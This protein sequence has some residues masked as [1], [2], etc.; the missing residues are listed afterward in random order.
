M[1]QKTNVSRAMGATPYSGNRL[2]ALDG[3]RAVA[4]SLV[5]L[6]H[7]G[8][9]AVATTIPDRQ[10]WQASL[11]R[12]TVGSTAS[13]VELFF[14]LSAIVLAG[15][16]VRGERHFSLGKYAVRRTARLLPP[17][18]AAWLLAGAQIY[19]MT[20]RPTWWSSQSSLPSFSWTDWLAQAG[21]IYI[22]HHPYNWAWWS[23]TIEVAFYATLPW[24]IPLVIRT[25]RWGR[26]LPIAFVTAVIVATALNW[27]G[28]ADSVP[29]LSQL[30]I[31]GS[32]FCA[33]LVI[34][35]KGPL[36]RPMRN[37]AVGI[38]ATWVLVSAIFPQLNAHVGWGLLYFGA[39]SMAMDRRTWLARTLS[40][41]RFVWLGERS[42]SLYLVHY[43][44][45]GL[46]C[47][48]A[49]FIIAA[50]NLKYFVLTRA[51]SL[52]ASFGAAV[53]LFGLIERRFAH[54]LVTANMTWP[55]QRQA[56]GVSPPSRNSTACRATGRPARR[57]PGGRAPCR[58]S[59]A[60]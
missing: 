34:A 11:S 60:P 53:F 5:L 23:L 35:A 12:L 37:A 8:A 52:I 6:H 2:H 57:H 56:G 39:V 26:G 17:Y 46:V 7:L 31:Y 15:P 41:F 58:S 19:L 44:M 20:V 10:W 18:F 28:L 45:I 21:I 47:Y 42:Y 59:R 14:V 50:K 25:N 22:G 33:G 1:D 40:D 30:A 3:L 54:N 55:W 27:L 32:C 36:N 9:R 4:A 38:G 51:L 24:L 49:S 29:I 16:Y 48:G 43:T 13:G